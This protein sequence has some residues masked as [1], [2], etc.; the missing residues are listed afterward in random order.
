LVVQAAQG[1]HFIVSLK[2]SRCPRTAG[3]RSLGGRR[4]VGPQPV[5]AS[6]VTHPQQRPPDQP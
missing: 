3:A 4:G 2:R 6:Q 1:M 5:T